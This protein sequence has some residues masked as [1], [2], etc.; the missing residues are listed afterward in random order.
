[1]VD[2]GHVSLLMALAR[3]WSEV[4]KPLDLLSAQ[5]DTVGCGVLF[6]AGDALGAGDGGDVVA[7]REEPGQR[8]LRR[9]R[10]ELGGDGLDLVDDAEVLFEV[11]FGEAGV[12]LAPVV[13]GEVFGERIVPVRKPCPSGE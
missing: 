2:D 5:L 13:V 9:C 3:S 1:M 7:L 11:A 8:D 10:I 12:V 4:V 6:D